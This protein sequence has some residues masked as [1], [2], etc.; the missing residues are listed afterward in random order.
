MKNERYSG[1]DYKNTLSDPQ[2]IESKIAKIEQK[3]NDRIL[4]SEQA[5]SKVQF[6][7]LLR[8]LQTA[9]SED[10]DAAAA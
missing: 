6:V 10:N 9:I 4:S 1:K 8:Q 5:E 2:E 7:Y 3:I